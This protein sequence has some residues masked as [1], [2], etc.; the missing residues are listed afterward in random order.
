MIHSVL[1]HCAV[2]REL[3]ALPN[4]ALR[5]TLSRLMTLM[6]S[7]LIRVTLV[8]GNVFTQ[9]CDTGNHSAMYS[10]ETLYRKY[11]ETAFRVAKCRSIHIRC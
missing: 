11:K 1:R 3:S 9:N 4:K 10:V 6:H 7:R 2:N 8:D 5:N